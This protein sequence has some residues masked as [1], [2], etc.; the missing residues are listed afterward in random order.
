ML[1]ADVY[2]EMKDIQ[3]AI[4]NL[5]QVIEIAPKTVAAYIRLGNIFR[6]KGDTKKG[7]SYYKQAIELNPKAAQA[8]YGLGQI[9]EKS[10]Q[11][12]LAIQNYNTAGQI[13]I[14]ISKECNM[15]IAELKL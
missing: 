9:Y 3:K 8:Y 11:I 4:M 7:E 14:K 13:D 15:K 1:K 5:Q 2:V 12:D 10:K 6:E